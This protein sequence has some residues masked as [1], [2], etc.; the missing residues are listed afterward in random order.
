VRAGFIL[1]P[2]RGASRVMYVATRKPAQSPVKRFRVRLFD[3]DRGVRNIVPQQHGREHHPQNAA[4][5][6]GQDVLQGVP[7]CDLA[8][9]EER[10]GD[11]RIQVCS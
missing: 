5:E 10:Q 9:A 7:E 11:R 6:L 8:E 3:V 1:I 4:H 2:D